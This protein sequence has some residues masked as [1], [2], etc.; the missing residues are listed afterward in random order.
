MNGPG[1][2]PSILGVDC[3]ES[4]VEKLSGSLHA[5]NSLMAI[6]YDLGILVEFFELC[7]A[8]IVQQHCSVEFR[9]GPLFWSTDVK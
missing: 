9:N 3:F 4:L 6:Q 5:S 8:L 2:K 7:D 1:V